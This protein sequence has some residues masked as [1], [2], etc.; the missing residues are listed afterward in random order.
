MTSVNDY[1]MDS[2]NCLYWAKRNDQ[3]TL[4]ITQGSFG[5]LIHFLH[6]PLITSS[7]NLHFTYLKINWLKDNEA[8]D[9]PSLSKKVLLNKIET[10]IPSI[11]EQKIIANFLSLIDERIQC[12]IKIIQKLESLILQFIEK[13]LNQQI[14][15]RIKII[16]L[17]G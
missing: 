11:S 5:L 10:R 14:R 1:L 2:E 9:V 3:Q 17:L 4:F 16:F 12:Q 6:I 7:L 15:L 13:T 8:S